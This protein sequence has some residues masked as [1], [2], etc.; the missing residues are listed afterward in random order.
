MGIGWY[1]GY[2]TIISEVTGQTATY[3]DDRLSVEP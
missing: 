1:D 3:G 2:R